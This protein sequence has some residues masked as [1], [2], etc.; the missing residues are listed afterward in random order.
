MRKETP[1]Y[2][3]TYQK[4]EGIHSQMAKQWNKNLEIDFAFLHNTLIT[5]FQK[6]IF[7]VQVKTNPTRM[8]KNLMSH[9]TKI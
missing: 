9:E 5:A 4:Q 8:Y 7:T 3:F 6:Y 2:I 1:Y